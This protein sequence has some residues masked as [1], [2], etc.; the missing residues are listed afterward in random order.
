MVGAVSGDIIEESL[1]EIA[2]KLRAAW[3]G[4]R[5]LTCPLAE[6]SALAAATLTF[7]QENRHMVNTQKTTH[8]HWTNYM[9][10]P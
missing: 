10:E 1:S 2:E 4:S 5:C 3:D 6:L 8:D 7:Y 9:R